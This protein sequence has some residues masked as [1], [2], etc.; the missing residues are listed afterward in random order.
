[1]EH[2]VLVNYHFCM[3]KKGPLYGKQYVPRVAERTMER[4]L[5]FTGC[6]VVRGPKAS[7]KSTLAMRFAKSSFSI[8]LRSNLLLAQSQPGYVLEGTSPRLI[9]EWQ[10]VPELW[11]YV[12]RSLDMDYQ[13]GKFILTGS[14]T[15]A[16]PEKILHS[17][18]GRFAALTLDTFTLYESGESLALVSISSLF[19]ENPPRFFLAPDENPFS[20]PRLAFQICRGGWPVSL[21]VDEKDAIDA[22]RHYF[23]FLFSKGASGDDFKVFLKGKSM[24][25]LRL[26]LLSLARNVSA[27]ARVSRMTSEIIASGARSRLDEETFA[28]YVKA[29]E[30]LY[31]VRNTEAWSPNI[32]GRTRVMTSPVRRFCD[33][34]IAAATLSLGPEQ[35]LGD[36]RTFGLFFEDFAF[37]ELIAYASS[38]GGKMCRYRDSTGLEVDGILSLPDG[39]YGAIEVK[40]RSEENIEKGKSALLRFKRKMEE[41]GARLP[42]FLMILT[43]HGEAYFDRGAGIFI[44]P[45]NTLLP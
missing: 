31:I 7:G 14:T 29:L 17:G 24:D 22:T 38:F 13:L 19:E 35:L 40:I 5:R 16:D 44:A 36:M 18:A 26:V 23:E 33:T 10:M 27:E 2:F 1:M 9:D 37:H 3:G 20:L 6:V 25:I 11:D 12:K 15:P 43:S 8:G 45:V 32:R 34:S 4:M 30:D 21:R 39:R 41:N 42:S 28:S